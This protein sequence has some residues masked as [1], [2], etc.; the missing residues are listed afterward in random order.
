[1]PCA[2]KPSRSPALGAFLCLSALALLPGCTVVSVT[3]SA[4]S[5]TASAVGLA[6]D[7]AV[8]TVKIVGKGVGKAVDAMDSDGTDNSGITV[9]YRTPDGQPLEP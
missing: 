7:A 6:A 5:V 8:G 3:A 4:V 2:H 9:R 1:M